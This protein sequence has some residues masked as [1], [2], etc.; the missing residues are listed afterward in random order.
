MESELFS[1]E[2]WD[3]HGSLAFMFYKVKLKVAIGD[4]PI[5]KTFSTAFVDYTNGLLQFD[6]EGVS[7]L[8][9]LHF[10]VGEWKGD[11]QDSNT[12]K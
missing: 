4:L 9:Q 8:F 2:G 7:Y 1:W 6:E 10:I 3:M 11:V 5:G 12:E